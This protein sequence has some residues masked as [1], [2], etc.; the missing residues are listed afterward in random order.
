MT[1][2]DL[3]RNRV[4]V[5]V[6]RYLPTHVGPPLAMQRAHRRGFRAGVEDDAT[7]ALR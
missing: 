7:T 1:A 5:I 6:P 4:K 3:V 2:N